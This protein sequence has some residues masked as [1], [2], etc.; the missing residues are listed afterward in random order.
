MKLPT[1]DTDWTAI[2]VKEAVKI[3]KRGTHSMNRDG[4]ATNYQLSSLYSK[5]LVKKTSPFVTNDEVR[6]H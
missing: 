2:G 1:R 4:G 6:Q 3:R 5:L